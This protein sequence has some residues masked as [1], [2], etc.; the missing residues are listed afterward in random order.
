M[1]YI[2][3]SAPAPARL[4]GLEL[5]AVKTT[6]KQFVGAPAQRQVLTA[7][8]VARHK[9]H[10]GR[11][12]HG[13]ALD[14]PELMRIELRQ[15]VVERGADQALV[16]C[17]EHAQ[18]FVGGAKIEHFYQRHRAHA[19]AHTNSDDTQ[20]RGGRFRLCHQQATQQAKVASKSMAGCDLTGKGQLH[21]S[22]RFLEPPGLY[23]LEQLVDRLRFKSL[24]GVL[25]KGG[26]K[27]QHW[28]RLGRA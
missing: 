18:L 21:L 13:A 24:H 26:D 1:K 10:P 20:E 4:H 22:H 9:R 5:V 3:G 16:L 17:C 28:E 15:Q 6:H 7:S 2:V 11:V 8:L 12:D 19:A 23:R 27:H 14:L 25:F